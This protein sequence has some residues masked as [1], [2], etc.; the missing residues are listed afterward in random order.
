M[1]KFRY[2]G[3]TGVENEQRKKDFE[4]LMRRAFA[5]LGAF[6][7]SDF[8]PYLSFIP[9]LQG[10]VSETQAV[11]A[12]V[13]K[14]MSGIMRL[15]KHMERALETSKDSEYVPDFIDVLLKARLADKDIMSLVNV[16]ALSPT[17]DFALKVS[18]HRS[19]NIVSIAGLDE[20]RDRHECIDGGM[21]NGGAH[22]KP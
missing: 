5:G 19:L 8:V 4:E 20:R 11:R 12:L 15:D 17:L 6:I 21:G 13:V 14:V 16:R 2:F 10:W 9:K 1:T 3:S 7:I 18:L 22:G